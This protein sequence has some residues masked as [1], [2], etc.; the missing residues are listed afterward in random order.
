MDAA[1]GLSVAAMLDAGVV[2]GGKHF[3]L[4]EQET[5]RSVQY[6]PTA[7]GTTKAY[8]SNADDKTTHETY[9]FP[10]YEA[11]KNGM[12][13]VMCAMVSANM[14]KLLCNNGLET[15]SRTESCQR[16]PRLRELRSPQQ[17]FENRVGL[18]RNGIP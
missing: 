2:P 4:N 17:A 8:S 15:N 13:G 7:G 1:F 14:S 12:G 9:L 5:N 6:S 18:P 11:V 16:Y 10:F 3:L